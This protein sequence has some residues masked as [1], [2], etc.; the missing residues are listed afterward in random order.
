MWASDN[1][2]RH[3]IVFDSPFVAWLLLS[4]DAEVW[5]P[6]NVVSGRHQL[7][8]SYIV[9]E[10]FT[11][12]KLVL[13]ARVTVARTRCFNPSGLVNTTCKNRRNMPLQG[14]PFC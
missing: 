5:Q 2:I 12:K 13:P 8:L 10:A 1:E 4:I 9:P 7:S 11:R 3:L 6:E 14:K